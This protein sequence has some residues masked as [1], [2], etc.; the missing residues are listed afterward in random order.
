M[1]GSWKGGQ[2]GKRFGKETDTRR[3]VDL[4]GS[5]RLSP[6]RAGGGPEEVPSWSDAARQG[7]REDSFQETRDRR[8]VE[9]RA[10]ETR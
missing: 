8:L 2:V 4:A 7:F 5:G 10:G 6:F 3:I 9:A 1:S